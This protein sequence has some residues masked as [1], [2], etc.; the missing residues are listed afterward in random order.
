MGL[1]VSNY[2][3]PYLINLFV[4]FYR[5]ILY[6]LTVIIVFIII[7]RELSEHFNFIIIKNKLSQFTLIIM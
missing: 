7:F 4:M 6:A 5:L 1:L 2:Y 3:R